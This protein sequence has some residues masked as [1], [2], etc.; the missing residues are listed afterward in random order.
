MLVEF[1]LKLPPCVGNIFK[2]M[3]F[4]LLE[5]A[6][7][8][9]IFTHALPHSNSPPSSF[10][11]ALGRRELLIPQGSILSKICFHQQQKGVEEAM[12]CFIKIRSE[13]MSMTWNVRFFMFCM[14]CNLVKCDRITVLYII[15]IT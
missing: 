6:L 3:E 7:I 12:V 13:N 15:S 4:I 1:S 11:H 8:Q 10:H 5:N 14:I 2:F 9:G